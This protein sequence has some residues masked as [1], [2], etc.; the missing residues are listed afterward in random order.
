MKMSFPLAAFVGVL[1]LA[2][3]GQQ[4][5]YAPT[6]LT[7]AESGYVRPALADFADEC[8]GP[9][10][11]SS[12]LGPALDNIAITTRGAHSEVVSLE[13]L[14]NRLKAPGDTMWRI[15]QTRALD[16]Q[17]QVTWPGYVARWTYSPSQGLNVLVSV[18]A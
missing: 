15:D 2:A 6:P 12:M 16:G 7:P 17:Q 3:C 8:Y 4:Q 13:C 18:S 5:A 14:L 9:G 11:A 10:A 1:T